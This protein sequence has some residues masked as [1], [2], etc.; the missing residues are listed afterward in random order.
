MNWQTYYTPPNPA[1][2]QGNF[3]DNYKSAYF[4]QQVKMLNLLVER[5]EPKQHASFALIGFECDEGIKRDQGRFGANEGPQMIRQHM[6]HL[7]IQNLAM[8]CYD[9]GNIICPDRQLENCQEALGEIISLLLKDNICPIII[10]GG[11]ELAWGQYLGISKCYPVEYRLGMINFDAHFELHPTHE[12]HP[13]S[14]VTIFHQIAKAHRESNRRLDYN[15]VGIQHAG[16]IRQSFEIARHFNTKMILADELHLGQKE[17]CIDFIDRV[18]DE[19]EIIYI[20]LSLDVFSA[21]HAPGVS[22]PQPLG[23][24]PWHILPLLRQVAASGKVI[25]YDIAEYLPRHDLDAHT[26]KLAAALIYEIIHHHKNF[27]RLW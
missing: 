15:C 2:W 13:N 11:H 9:A 18:I 17:K 20:S 27:S 3:S 12:K 26:A 23:L 22:A 24:A 6:Q 8:Q 5:P 10:G 21:A 1:L 19:N 25:S 7:P 14:G 4:Y 16:N